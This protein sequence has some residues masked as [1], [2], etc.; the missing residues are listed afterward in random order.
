[1]LIELYEIIWTLHFY[2]YLGFDKFEMKISEVDV[3]RVNNEEFTL[4][5]VKAISAEAEVH[6][7]LKGLQ[8]DEVKSRKVAQVV[9]MSM[10][11]VRPGD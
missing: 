6:C 5:S 10:L 2:K 11:R 1:M 9:A 3:I 4:Y 7:R 8:N